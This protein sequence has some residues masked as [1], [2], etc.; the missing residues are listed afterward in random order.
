[1]QNLYLGPGQVAALDR[2]SLNSRGLYHR[3]HVYLL[4]NSNKPLQFTTIA[5]HS[6]DI[7]YVLL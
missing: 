4:F 2:W 1:M 6:F 7:V 5:T 3:F